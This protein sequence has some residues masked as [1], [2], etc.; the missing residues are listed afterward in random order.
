MT[1]AI[2]A[3][4]AEAQLAY[5]KARW[6]IIGHT[7]FV[8]AVTI[9]A[10]LLRRMFKMPGML[11]GIAF[12]VALIVFGGDIMTFFRARDRLKR[13]QEAAHS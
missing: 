9:A 2:E 8:V 7:V 10:A 4:L 11:L 5:R 6:T 13:A 12:I 1:A 3:E